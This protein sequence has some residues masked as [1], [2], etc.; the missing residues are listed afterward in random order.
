MI[1]FDIDLHHG[2][3]TQQI[4]WEI[5]AAVNARRENEKARSPRKGSPKKSQPT[6]PDLQILYTS[7]HDIQSYRTSHRTSCGLH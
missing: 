5:N 1:I 3:G 7:L 6:K 4:A 2:D